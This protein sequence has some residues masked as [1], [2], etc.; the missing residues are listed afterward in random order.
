[1]TTSGNDAAESKYFGRPSFNR[2]CNGREVVQNHDRRENYYVQDNCDR[3]YQ[4]SR[5]YST[6]FFKSRKNNEVQLCSACNRFGYM[7]QNCRLVLRLC[8]ICGQ[9]NHVMREC[10]KYFGN[11]YRKDNRS[12]NTYVG[13]SN[14]DGGAPNGQYRQRQQNDIHQQRQQP[15]QRFYQG[16]RGRSVSPQYM[17]KYGYN[18]RSSSQFNDYNN[19]NQ[20]NNFP[21]RNRFDYQ[22]KSTDYQQYLN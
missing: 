13:R 17:Q 20:N 4:D 2:K 21:N 22:R 14:L 12:G 10:P 6:R 18:K 9:D 3:S 7:P 5:Q 1:M 19:N 15:S 11:A 16:Q 8:F